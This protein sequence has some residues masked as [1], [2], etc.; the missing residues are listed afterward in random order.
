MYTR[1]ITEYVYMEK[2]KEEEEKNKNVKLIKV[3]SEYTNTKL[4]CE[5]DQPFTT[6][7][8]LVRFFLDGNHKTS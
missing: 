3:T 6:V 7:C 1:D 5:G 4:A 2:K 8:F